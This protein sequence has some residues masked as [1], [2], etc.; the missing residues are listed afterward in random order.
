MAGEKIFKNRATKWSQRMGQD[1]V[2]GPVRLGMALDTM[3]K[4]SGREWASVVDDATNEALNRI[5]RIHFDYGQ[6][7][8]FD[9][10]ARRLIPFWTFMSRNLPL[11]ISQMWTKPRAYNHYSSFVRNFKGEDDEL[12]PAYFE[13]IGAFPFADV[14]IGGDP[15]YL[16]PDLPHL[17]V[18]EEIENWTDF[19]QGKNMLRPFSDFNPF[20]TAPIELATGKDF[21]TNRNY[22]ET[23]VSKAGGVYDPI[24]RLLSPTQFSEVVDGQPVI[25]DRMA[26][27]L[28][29]VLPPLDRTTRLFPQS[30][31]EVGDTK[32]QVESIARTFGIP[33]R[34]LT[35]KQRESTQWSQYFDEQDKQA[36]QEAMLRAAAG[37]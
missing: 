37:L 35:D 22:D 7:S 23:D 20:F 27:F 10:A 8:E 18:T 28:R 4:Y 19:A 21:F 13:N 15:L 26:N 1:W 36:E 9:E 24:A 31:G 34:S 14:E 25:Q 30:A 17:R 32:R 29:A 5:T 33:I 16:Q 11:Q 12:A 6:V 3:S 2:E